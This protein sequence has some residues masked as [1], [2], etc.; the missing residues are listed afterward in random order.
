MVNYEPTVPSSHGCQHLDDADAVVCR[1][2]AGNG[3]HL[4]TAATYRRLFAL[5][6]LWKFTAQTVDLP[7]GTPF[8]LKN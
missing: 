4:L 5:M 7:T 1:H 8:T 3:Q 2:M 6:A